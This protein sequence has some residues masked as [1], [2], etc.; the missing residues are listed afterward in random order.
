MMLLR[1]LSWSSPK[2]PTISVKKK[3]FGTCQILINIPKV[4]FKK[5]FKIQRFLDI[6]NGVG[7]NDQTLPEDEEFEFQTAV[8]NHQHPGQASQ[9][10]Q[11]PAEN[12]SLASKNPGVESLWGQNLAGQ[13]T[14]YS[15]NQAGHGGGGGDDDEFEFISAPG[16][17]EESL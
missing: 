8:T 1:K 2:R 16:Q 15:G 9:I 10:G 13:N 11:N 6:Q 12:L 5:I 7:T 14:T 17:R 3:N 4:S